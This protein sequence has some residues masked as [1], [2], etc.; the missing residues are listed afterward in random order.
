MSQG[1]PTAFSTP[2]TSEEILV[3]TGRSLSDTARTAAPPASISVVVP[4]YNSE[5]SLPLLIQRLEPV[6]R[7]CTSRF[8]IILVDDCSNDRS[9]DV[10]V[11]LAQRC[12]WVRGIRLLRNFGQH[13]ALL[14]GIRAAEHE[15]TVTLDDDLQNP[16][17]EIPRLLEKLAEG[18][19]VVYGTPNKEQHGFWRDLGSQVTK[20]ALQNAMGAATARSVSAFR[21]F[22]TQVRDAFANYQGP[23]VSVDVLLTWGTTKF[24]AIHVRH[25]PRRAGVSNYNFRRLITHALNMMTGFSTLPLQFASLMGFAFTLFGLGVLVYVVGRYLLEGSIVPGFSFLASILAI[26]CGTQLFALGIIGEYLARMHFRM[27]DRPTYAVRERV[28]LDE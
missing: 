23:F 6:L 2:G 22:R 3:K 11:D 18:Y 27:M 1:I 10:I 17:E 25:D 15:V 24:A 26:L 9:W 19:D 8:E 13:N 7:S 12:P 4:V 5:A 20:L 28:N 14:C 16:P 21:A